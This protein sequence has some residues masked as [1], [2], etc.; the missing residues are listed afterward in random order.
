MKSDGTTGAAPGNGDDVVL[1]G[2]PGLALASIAPA[3]QSAVTLNSLTVRASF[4][5]Q[6]GSASTASAGFFGYWKIG[7]AAWTID[8]KGSSR[9]KFNGG[10]VASTVTILSTGP[11]A[12]AGLEPV[13]WVGTNAANKLY[14]TGGTAGV[15]T[16]LPGEA[17]TLAEVDVAGSQAA[18]NLGP[19]VAWTAANVS[20][21]A[22]LSAPGG[23]TTLSVSAGSSATV[24]GAAAVTAV[25]NAG[26]VCPQQPPGLLHPQRPS[27][28]HDRLLRQPR[29][30]H[31]RGRQ[32]LSGFSRHA[33]SPPTP[34]TSPSPP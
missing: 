19:A 12:D 26:A 22:T 18:L 15:G 7:A 27:R 20:A 3:D 28:Q 32:P 17:A 9:L 10:A 21:G 2:I 16:N 23:G 4:S 30:R 29:L 24:N 33:A 8:G 13:R 14:V 11:S 1:A 25:N 6:V 31:G 5:A 34:A